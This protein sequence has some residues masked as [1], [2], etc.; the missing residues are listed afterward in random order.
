[1][2]A[3]LTPA[4]LD[5]EAQAVALVRPVDLERRQILYRQRWGGFGTETLLQAADSVYHR[6]LLLYAGWGGL[7]VFALIMGLVTHRR[8]ASVAGN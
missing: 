6:R 8:R 3:W 4:P 5:A 7:A 2:F 1:M